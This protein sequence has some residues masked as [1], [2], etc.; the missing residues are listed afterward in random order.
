[1]TDVHAAAAAATTERPAAAAA[2]STIAALIGV[3]AES[4]RPLFTTTG[5][6]R[7]LN[8]QVTP[9]SFFHCGRRQLAAGRSPP[10]AP[11][12]R[13][14]VPGAAPPVG[15][16]R[17]RRPIGRRRRRAPRRR[18]RERVDADSCG[19]GSA[20]RDAA[21]AAAVALDAAVVEAEAVIK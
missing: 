4:V 8:S 14:V 21:A 18:Q 2:A 3:P 1:M 9:T 10:L 16:G 6:I 11:L 20:E 5:G 12:V 15:V 7:L 19:S 17:G 13:A